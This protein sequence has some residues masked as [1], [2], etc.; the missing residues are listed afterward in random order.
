[1]ISKSAM[2]SDSAYSEDLNKIISWLTMDIAGNKANRRSGNYNKQ[3]G[4]KQKF[5]VS[6]VGVDDSSP[7]SKPSKNP[8]GVD[9]SDTTKWFEK[10][11]YAKLPPEWRR[12]CSHKRYEA[13]LKKN[14]DKGKATT[15]DVKK[16]G[17][18]NRINRNKRNSKYI[19]EIIAKQTVELEAK[20]EQKIA[21][22]SSVSSNQ[23]SRGVS[24]ISSV[25]TR[26]RK[27]SSVQRTNTT[28]VGESAALELDSH[29]DTSVLDK[30]FAVLK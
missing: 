3:N 13:Y 8:P 26:E 16:V 6:E 30:N 23:N 20:F 10:E 11:D 7:P 22:V 27:I 18:N 14:K 9:V 1:M 2:F 21:S 25:Q 15:N 4:K 19:K 28:N 12:Y 17:K 29:A 5:I 24:F